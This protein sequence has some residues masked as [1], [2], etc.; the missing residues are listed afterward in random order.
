MTASE[1]TL[2]R[3]LLQQNRR[4]RKTIV[5]V[6]RLALRLRREI[7]TMRSDFSWIERPRG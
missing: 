7:R 6:Y 2:F 1:R 3:Y 4:N 5:K